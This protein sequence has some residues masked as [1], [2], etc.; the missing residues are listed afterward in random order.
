MSVISPQELAQTPAGPVR[1]PLT[2]LKTE[3]ME[4]LTGLVQGRG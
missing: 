4:L 3:E 1:P 2:E